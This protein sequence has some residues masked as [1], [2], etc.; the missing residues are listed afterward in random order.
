MLAQAWTGTICFILRAMPAGQSSDR[1][2]HA[3]PTVDLRDFPYMWGHQSSDLRSEQAW[4]SAPN[5]TR[6]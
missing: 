4:V 2:G 5:G 6:G 3:V 1:G